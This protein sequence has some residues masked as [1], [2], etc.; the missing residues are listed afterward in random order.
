M[1][2]GQDVVDPVSPPIALRKPSLDD[3]RQ[4]TV[5]YFEDD[6]LVPVTQETRKAVQSATQALREAGF[7]VEPFRPPQLEQLR[8]LWTTFFV[9]CGALFYEPEIQGKHAQL[10]PVFGEFL[11]I[12]EAAGEFSLGNCSSLWRSWISFGRSSW[13]K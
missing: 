11:S 4:L 7:R 1:L 8:K 10:S 9:Q 3:V 6:G 2:A 13:L 5:G 12:A